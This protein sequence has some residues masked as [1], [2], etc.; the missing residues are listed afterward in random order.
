[1]RLWL[2]E[3][4]VYR[5][6]PLTMKNWRCSSTWGN[7]C[8]R[9]SPIALIPPIHDRVLMRV[10]ALKVPFLFLL[11][12]I[13]LNLPGQVATQ[14]YGPASRHPSRTCRTFRGDVEIA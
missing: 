4:N 14:G 9:L 12:L 1:M 3:G 2:A 11:P 13:S 5:W 10:F 6:F 8:L 7:A